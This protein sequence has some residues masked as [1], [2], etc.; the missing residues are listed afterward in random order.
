MVYGSAFIPTG[1]T[2]DT[3][4]SFAILDGSKQSTSRSYE[5]PE[6]NA[7]GTILTTSMGSVYTIQPNADLRTLVITS[8]AQQEQDK[9]R[10][11]TNSERG[12][13]FR[14]KRREYEAELH[15]MVNAL[16]NEVN[17]LDMLRHIRQEKSVN[18]RHSMSGSLVRLVQEYFD[19]FSCGLPTAQGA[20]HKRMITDGSEQNMH[21]KQEAFLKFAM[22]PDMVFDDGTGP[23]ALLEQW[24]RYTSFHSSLRVKVVK[25][26]M[27]DTDGSPVV[28][29]TSHLCVRFS[30][31]TFENVFPHCQDNEEL[32]K[33]FLGKEVIYRGVNHLHFD[34]KGQI[35]LYN[36]DVGFMDALIE[37][38]AT[39]KD[40]ALL[41]PG[42]LV[43][44]GML[45]VEPEES[46]VSS[47]SRFEEVEPEPLDRVRDPLQLDFI[48][49]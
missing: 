27:I 3:R 25:M 26:E 49:S 33:K 16:R 32:V 13:A 34:S 10:A 20:G 21:M 36:S 39:I 44:Q 2:S 17:D 5:S 9:R 30:H 43:K 12:K 4:R 42:A 41:M 8:N 40:L 35:H 14:A 47:P 37:A 29:V 11:K 1:G 48:L 22:A 18:L 15:T 6:R 19:I 38:G 31:E 23:M 45:G 7:I 46:P 24:R 28:A